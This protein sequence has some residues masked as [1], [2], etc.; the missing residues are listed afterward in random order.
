MRIFV[1][2][3]TGLLGGHFVRRLVEGRH[4]VVALV[5]D[6]R[7]YTPN[8]DECRNKVTEIRG[9][10]S[11][12]RTIERALFEYRIDTV[13]HLAAQTQVRV[14]DGSPFTTF[15]SNIRGTYT[16]LEACRSYGQLN[17]VVIASSDKSYGGQECPYVETQP[18]G[19]E[20][21]YDV[22]KSCGDMIARSYFKTYQLPVVTVRC[23]NLY[24]PGDLNWQRIIPATCRFVFKEEPLVL[25]GGGKMKRD[26]LY[27]DDAVQA[28]MNCILAPGIDGEAFN[29]GSG[30]PT[31]IN[32][33][34][35]RILNSCDCDREPEIH[36]DHEK[37]IKH[38]WMDSTKAKEVLGWE[39]LTTLAKGLETTVEWYRTF[40]EKRDAPNRIDAGKV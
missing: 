13:V 22:S 24:G 9:D 5:R 35:T 10:L 36:P 4:D 17:R 29:F 25:R 40:L 39:P 19:G 6:S 11:D 1:T 30:K 18:V 38:Q 8:Y 34:V 23:C 12:F 15:E 3:A 37:E 20:Y 2:G 21:P 7:G 31:E 33:I 14:S 16:V 32:E 28:Y 27:V 26:Y